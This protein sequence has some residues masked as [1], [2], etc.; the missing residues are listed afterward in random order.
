[1]KLAVCCSGGRRPAAADLATVRRMLAAMQGD[2][3]AGRP[4]TG[5]A[6]AVDG[7]ALGWLHT[8]DVG[9]PVRTASTSTAG[10][11]LLVAGVPI[12]LAGDPARALGDTLARALAAPLDD[13]EK[14]LTSLDGGF[15]AVRWCAAS[16]RLLVVTDFMGFQP[17]HRA[18]VGPDA[19]LLLATELKALAATGLVDTS[20]DPAAWGAFVG[21]GHAIGDQTL[22]AGVR[23]VSPGTAAR[24]E[25]AAPSGSRP[26]AERT[27]W[28]WPA[29]GAARAPEEVDTAPLVDA[30]AASVTAYH[31]AWRRDGVVLLSGGFDSRLV[32]AL[33]RR[34][35]IPTRALVVRHPDELA[36]ADGR[37]AER[38]AGRLGVAVETHVP[39][40]DFYLGADYRRY[41]LRTELS[42]PSLG[43]FIARVAGAIAPAHGAVWE[44]IAPNA[45]QRLNRNPT[46]GG[47]DAYLANACQPRR[48]PVWRAMD[49]ILDR[50]WVDACYAAHHAHLAE[51]RARLR[52]DEFGV[53]EFAVRNRTRHR[54]AANP[55]AGFAHDALALTPGV[56]RRFFD[57]AYSLSGHAL[58]KSAVRLKLWR[59]HFPEWL[60][61]PF[62]SGGGLY[63]R[64][65][66]EGVELGLL[67]LRARLGWR[68]GARRALD[69]LL[70]DRGP[71]TFA[72]DGVER[73]VLGAPLPAVVAGVPRL[74]AD[75]TRVAEAAGATGLA[76]PVR[77]MA[78]ARLFYWVAAHRLLV[79]APAR[80]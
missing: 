21:F 8:A 39:A 33:L 11:V 40:A 14:L 35:G 1:M 5:G 64:G 23:R 79:A 30:L 62:C 41:L 42:N 48:A 27:H 70:G 56:T 37:L 78:R 34:A 53:F 36:D 50:D 25:P 17:L 45:M 24:W 73:A 28:R 13:A 46:H 68:P 20:P 19:P 63:G 7:G 16:R 58:G 60:A 32:L 49:A 51:L 61:E 29:P 10:D 22:L 66:G 38:T 4:W 12:Q 43:L 18:T 3:P 2:A 77:A 47:F 44:G 9:A 55:F 54:L 75:A 72:L 71:R 67:R 15:A 59:E 26:I 65:R 80:A 69:A 6:V 31:R 74:R 76:P 57:V 52:D